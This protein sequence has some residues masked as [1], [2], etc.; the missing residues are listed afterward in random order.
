MVSKSLLKIEIVKKLDVFCPNWS[1]PLMFIT[2]VTNAPK[3]EHV[4]WDDE[5]AVIG[6][7]LKFPN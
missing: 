4:Y 6:A 3:A 2:V 1:T 5:V 7:L